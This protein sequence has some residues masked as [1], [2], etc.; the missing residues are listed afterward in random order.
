MKSKIKNILL[1]ALLT[2]SFQLSAVSNQELMSGTLIHK[3]K[4]KGKCKP[5]DIEL[6]DIE[7][8]I[9]RTSNV[10]EIDISNETVSI[11]FPSTSDEVREYMSLEE[12]VLMINR[13][14]FDINH[15]VLDFNYFNVSKIYKRKNKKKNIDEKKEIERAIK[16]IENTDYSIKTT[17]EYTSI[18]YQATSSWSSV[19]GET[20]TMYV[21][22]RTIITPYH[23]Y[24]I[25]SVSPSE[26][27]PESIEFINSFK[28]VK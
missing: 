24:N 20:V 5:Y 10:L 18:D 14:H 27:S 28:V 1:L 19:E 17:E 2:M 22:A 23:V 12:D 9:T 6:D 16:L 13:A 4:G 15:E 21:Y 11:E 3:G 25:G 26:Y 8:D 7:L